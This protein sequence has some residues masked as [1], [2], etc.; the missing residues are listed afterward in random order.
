M[1]VIISSA[2][3]IYNKFSK[4][5]QLLH[6]LYLTITYNYASTFERMKVISNKV[7]IKILQGGTGVVINVISWVRSQVCRHSPPHVWLLNHD[8]IVST[9]VLR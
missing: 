9:C 1:Y 5:L 6:I 2:H 4:L 3:N 7:I 8:R